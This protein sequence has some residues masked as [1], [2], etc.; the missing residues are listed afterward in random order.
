[1]GIYKKKKKSLLQILARSEKEVPQRKFHLDVC[2]I[3]IEKSFLSKTH[4]RSETC[5]L[6]SPSLEGLYVKYIDIFHKGYN[7]LDCTHFPK[8]EIFSI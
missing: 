6:L 2:G 8:R 4:I 1:M 3:S 7:D 5:L